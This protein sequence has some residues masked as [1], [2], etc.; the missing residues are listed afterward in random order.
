MD[1]GDVKKKPVSALCVSGIMQRETCGSK[2]K[3]S[4][5]SGERGGARM[6]I[7]KITSANIPNLFEQCNAP[8]NQKIIMPVS[9][10]IQPKR[11]FERQFLLHSNQFFS[12]LQK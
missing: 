11:R 10:D 1:I 9:R 2:S 5:R 12:P 3:D 6:L 4:P 8:K 7:S